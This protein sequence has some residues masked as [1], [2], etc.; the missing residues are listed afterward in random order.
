MQPQRG[1]YTDTTS[2]DDDGCVSDVEGD[3]KGSMVVGR[4]NTLQESRLFYS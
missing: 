2:F 4:R 3:Q 1:K